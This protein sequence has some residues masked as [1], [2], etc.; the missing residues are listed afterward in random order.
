MKKIV[1]SLL[2]TFTFATFSFAQ[3]T[4][5]GA[6]PYSVVVPKNYTRTTGNNDLA[7]VQW[8]NT[9]EEI[10]G[11]VFFEHKDDLI[12]N[13]VKFDL[14][15]YANLTLETYN[16]LK[17]Y[18]LINSK[19]FKTKNGIET[20]QKEF[21]YYD[22]ENDIKFHMFLNI[23]K[24]NDFIYLMMNYGNENNVKNNTKDIDFII[25]SFKL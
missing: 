19:K 9:D 15:S 4:L 1:L 12:H 7:T 11:Y 2:I 5:V 16:T 17:G 10:Y 21:K 18:K 14:E 25:N 20:I 22:D 24:S 8:E 13:D 3:T 23:Y 6:E